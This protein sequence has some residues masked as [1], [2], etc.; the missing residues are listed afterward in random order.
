MNKLL[1]IDGCVGSNA[2]NGQFGMTSVDD[3]GNVGPARKA[4]RFMMNGEHIAE[5]VDGVVLVDESL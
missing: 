4:T 3:V 1:A 5:A 2:M